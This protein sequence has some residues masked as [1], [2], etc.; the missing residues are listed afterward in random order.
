MDELLAG[1]RVGLEV[2]EGAYSRSFTGVQSPCDLDTAMQL[3]H[4]LFTT[5]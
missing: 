1:K 3:I 4:L 5:K 2:S